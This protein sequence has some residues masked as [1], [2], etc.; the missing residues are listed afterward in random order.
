MDPMIDDPHGQ[1]DPTWQMAPQSRD[2]AAARSSPSVLITAPPALGRRLAIEIATARA[3]ED[4]NAVVV[5]VEAGDRHRLESA[6]NCATAGTGHLRAMVVHDVDALDAAQQA[7]F[8]AALS[9][10]LRQGAHACRIIA[11]TA[12]AVFDRVL[13]GSFHAGLFYRLNTI[14]I[15]LDIGRGA[16]EVPLRRSVGGCDHRIAGDAGSRGGGIADTLS[17]KGCRGDLGPCV[18]P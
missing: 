4:G 7:A 12:V 8:T 17:F 6:L 3:D 2:I 16:A 14:H 9:H 18:P 11:T 5:V 1:P 15:R 10:V 13:Q